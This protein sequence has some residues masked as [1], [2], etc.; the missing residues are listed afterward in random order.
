MYNFTN[1]KGSI[2]VSSKTSVDLWP[3]VFQSCLALSASSLTSAI[4]IP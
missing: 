2:Q 4:A 3:M 1:F